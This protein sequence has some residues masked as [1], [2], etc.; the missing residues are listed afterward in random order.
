MTYRTGKMPATAR[1]IEI[2]RKVDEYISNNGYSPNNCEV[3]KMVNA[4][5]V[6]RQ[7]KSLRSQGLLSFQDGAGRTFVLTEAGKLALADTPDVDPPLV[8]V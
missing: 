4:A 1:Q 2:L 6:S 5:N 7:L 3:A 8:T